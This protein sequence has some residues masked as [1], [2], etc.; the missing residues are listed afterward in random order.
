MSRHFSSSCLA[1]ARHYY[2]H[3]RSTSSLRKAVSH[4]ALNKSRSM[5]LLA[6][7][8]L[9]AKNCDWSDDDESSSNEEGE[10]E[11]REDDDDDH[12]DEDDD[13]ETEEGEDE[14]SP[15][16]KKKKKKEHISKRQ[17][18][19]SK[20]KIT[21]LCIIFITAN[22]DLFIQIPSHLPSSI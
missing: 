9:A 8:F 13:V 15:C 21:Q 20:W 19:S 1:A 11:E 17:Q 2:N 12:E 22:D 6:N 7:G 18:K 5:N 10:V 16:S 3:S 14:K 4:N